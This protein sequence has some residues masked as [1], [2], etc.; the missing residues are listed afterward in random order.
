M[1]DCVVNMEIKHFVKLNQQSECS[2]TIRN[3]LPTLR[4]VLNI[5]FSLH[6]PRFSWSRCFTFIISM[7][8]ALFLSEIL[9]Y[10]TNKFHNT[11]YIAFYELS[12]D[13][14][15]W[16]VNPMSIFM[17]LP[18][19]YQFFTTFLYLVLVWGIIFKVYIHF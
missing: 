19:N 8:R 15:I 5:I 4:I 11:G 10:Q 16:F 18:S 6:R 3:T 2:L 7:N 12:R 13:R 1:T 9:S 14:E 17:D